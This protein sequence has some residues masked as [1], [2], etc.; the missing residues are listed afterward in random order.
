MGNRNKCLIIT[1]IVL[2]GV[3]L[4]IFLASLIITG[5]NFIAWFKSP[6]FLWVC[7]ILGLYLIGVLALIIWEKISKL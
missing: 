3:A 5:F 2:I 6:T 4:V 7:V 1:S